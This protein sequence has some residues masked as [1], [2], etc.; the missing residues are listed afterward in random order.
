M[1]QLQPTLN[2]ISIFGNDNKLDDVIPRDMQQHGSELI[3]FCLKVQ[4]KHKHASILKMAKYESTEK[5]FKELNIKVMKLG[6]E[7]S[8][9]EDEMQ[10]LKDKLTKNTLQTLQKV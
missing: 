9:M 1:V 5:E 7:V 8:A 3:L 2:Y 6:E 10:V 4:L